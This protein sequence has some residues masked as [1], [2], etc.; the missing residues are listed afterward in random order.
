MTCMQYVW[1]FVYPKVR[2]Q[3]ALIEGIWIP[4]G[5]FMSNRGIS[6]WIAVN[7]KIMKMYSASSVYFVGKVVKNSFTLSWTSHRIEFKSNLCYVN[8]SK[9]HSAS[10]H[11]FHCFILAVFVV[12]G[13]GKFLKWYQIWFSYSCFS[14]WHFTF[15]FIK[16]FIRIFCSVSIME[17]NENILFL[18]NWLCTVNNL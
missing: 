15:K 18:E 5:Y 14:L 3:W 11:C 2:N 10:M 12:L 4:D 8:C 6:G 1:P 9:F 16:E 17:E 13:C 7:W